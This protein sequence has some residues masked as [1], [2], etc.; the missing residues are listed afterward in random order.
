MQAFDFNRYAKSRSATKDTVALAA[1]VGLD[2]DA[3][4]VVPNPS[5]E[6]VAYRFAKAD[7]QILGIDRGVAGSAGDADPCYRIAVRK[8]AA[9]VRLEA[10]TVARFWDE[11]AETLSATAA[12]LRASIVFRAN[13]EGT[14]SYNGL[15][16]PCLGRTTL[17]YPTD[18][19]INVGDKY[20]RRYST[21]FG[22]WM[23]F[24]VLIWG[25]RGIFIHEGPATLAE[26]GGETAGCIHLGAPHAEAFFDWITGRTRITIQY[27][28]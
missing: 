11:G 9:C 28:W 8:D 16:R 7:V 1:T 19:T 12:T 27:P 17:P 3:Y 22:V 10:G 4:I 18:L 15:N 23:D 25:Q 14:L 13:G 6:T 21:E 2:G 24:A 20:R 26:N 5:L